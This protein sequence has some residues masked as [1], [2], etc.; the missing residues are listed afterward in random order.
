M[1][2]PLSS[3]GLIK[4]TKSRV[5]EVELYT[6]LWAVL[7]K[8]RKRPISAIRRIK[9][10]ETVNSE[11]DTVDYVIESPSRP[12]LIKIGQAVTSP[13]M[14]EVVGYRYFFSNS[15]LVLAHSRR[16]ALDSPILHINQCGLTQGC[17][18]GDLN[19]K[20]NFIWEVL[21]QSPLISGR[22]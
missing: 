9:T 2:H 12:N 4:A 16:R 17:P 6:V 22:K 15:F 11:I 14:G 8:Y 7:C 21:P 13:Y 3:R 19:T 20:T 1:Q 18:F 10:L 5:G